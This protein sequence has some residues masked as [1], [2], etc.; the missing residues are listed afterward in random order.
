MKL[1]IK[2]LIYKVENQ[3]LRNRI[4][5]DFENANIRKKL[6]NVERNV[7]QIIKNQGL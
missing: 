3:G 7:K 6:I 2:K 4:L 1:E 5:K